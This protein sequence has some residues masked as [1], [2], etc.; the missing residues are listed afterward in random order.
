MKNLGI[1][2]LILLTTSFFSQTIAQTYGL[3]S[4]SGLCI[5]QN[6]WS[7]EGIWDSSISDYEFN[8]AKGIEF[9][10][11]ELTPFEARK[12]LSNK[13]VIEK[14]SLM[15]A[16]SVQQDSI[17]QY[18]FSSDTDS[19]LSLKTEYNYDSN[20]NGFSLANYNWDA[21]INEWVGSWKQE[22]V[23]DLSGNTVL[24]LYYNWDAIIKDWVAYYRYE[25]N[26]NTS[27]YITLGTSY[28]WDL[29]I[30]N[31]VGSRNYES[32]YDVEGNKILYLIYDWDEDKN[33]W[34]VDLKNEYEYDN[35]DSL[36]LLT[37]YV[38]DVNIN[39]WMFRRKTGY[40]YDVG[41]NLLLIDRY[42]W[43]VSINDWVPDWKGE[44]SYDGNNNITIEKKSDWDASIND[45][46]AD[47]KNI[48][49]YNID[50]QYIFYEIFNWDK[51][52]NDWL[53]YRKYEYS[54][55]S[56]G[57]KILSLGNVW[58]DSMNDW[59]PYLKYIFSIDN[60]GSRIITE[61]FE[62]DASLNG[63]ELTGK[64]FFYYTYIPLQVETDILSFSFNIP[65]QLGSAVINNDSHTIELEVSQDT[66]MSNLVASF[67]LSEG[68]AAKVDG[69]VQESGITANDFSNPI[70]YTITAA[71]KT[72][73]QDWVVTVNLAIGIGDFQNEKLR[74]Y[75][76]P[77][78]ESLSIEFG[79]PNQSK[80]KLTVYSISGRKVFE[81]DDITTEKLEFKPVNLAKGIYI[82]ELRGQNIF[83][84]RI[85]VK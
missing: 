59:M 46:V 68:A 37:N 64:T 84:E 75:P 25:S 82:I 5:D 6:K 60:M 72:T 32:S 48:H 34:I 10:T 81:K 43:D 33:D 66:D 45:W 40:T 69:L 47:W 22:L 15:D 50:G 16:F 49:S 28:D 38:W 27:G 36:I 21:N 73:V 74:I 62:W 52:I 83:R 20:G 7:T 29:S 55:N 14:K 31:W 9:C 12:F 67:T 78:S 70:T 51:S 39:D 8:F 1:L 54:Y 17:I 85:I 53:G 76:N 56:N 58:N 3:S 2:L 44:S 42:N 61:K 13:G 23:Y 30:N 80:Y 57:I 4:G 19:V 35:K 65:P 18:N 24:Y 79:N 63:W 77:F 26:Y 11:D 41:G 71:D